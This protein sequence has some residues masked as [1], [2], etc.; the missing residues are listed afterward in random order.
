MK[1]RLCLNSLLLCLFLLQSHFPLADKS[2]VKAAQSFLDSLNPAQKK[3]AT[4]PLMDE[5]RYNWHF[6]PR[7]R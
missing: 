1:K 2:I 7:V 4:Y 3:Q 5:E 6:T